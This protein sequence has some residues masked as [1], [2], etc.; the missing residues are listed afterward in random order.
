MIIIDIINNDSKKTC[1]SA[2]KYAQQEIGDYFS[3]NQYEKWR[4]IDMPSVKQIIKHYGTFNNAKLK[5]KIPFYRYRYT[6]VDEVINDIRQTL[7]RIGYL[8]T[9]R[10]YE[11]LN[12]KPTKKTMARFGLTYGKIIISMGYKP[13]RIKNHTKE[14]LLKRI[15]NYITLCNGMVISSKYIK[16]APKLNLPSITTL[17]KHFGS[18][19]NAIEAAGGKTPSGKPDLK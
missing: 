13:N 3:I 6:S 14:Q 15:I 10:E 8:P 7:N 5:L 19:K 16:D 11:K 17:Q 2:L 1:I 12:L 18:F 9:A 4:S